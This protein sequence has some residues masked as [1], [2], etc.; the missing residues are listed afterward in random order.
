MEEQ[1]YFTKKDVIEN[2]QPMF[3]EW[4]L[5]KLIKERKLK[6]IRIGR[7]IYI[8][9]QA[10]EEFIKSEEAHS[11]TKEGGDLYIV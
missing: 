6:N 10:V 1:K 8:T 5:S 9:K 2:Y 4:S 11:V 7:N 3:T